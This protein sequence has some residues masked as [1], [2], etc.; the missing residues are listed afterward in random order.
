MEEEEILN[1]PE[2]LSYQA[3]CWR[4]VQNKVSPPE[5]VYCC[6]TGREPPVEKCKY[7]FIL[8]QTLDKV[9]T[10]TSGQSTMLPFK[11]WVATIFIPC[12]TT[13]LNGY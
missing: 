5:S 11:I 3:L 12:Q 4:A 1:L 2:C 6:S 10:Q 8:K 9:R 7:I 13:T